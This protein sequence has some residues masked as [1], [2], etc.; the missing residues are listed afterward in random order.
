M[1]VPATPL[2]EGKFTKA[3]EHCQDLNLEGLRRSLNG[4]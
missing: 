4:V 2:A 1:T 3:A